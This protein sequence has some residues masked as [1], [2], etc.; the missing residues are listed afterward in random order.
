M[1]RN[2]RNRLLDDRFFD[3]NSEERSVIEA[4]EI[5]SSK[6]MFNMVLHTQPDK[7]MGLVRHELEKIRSLTRTAKSELALWLRASFEESVKMEQYVLSLM[8]YDSSSVNAL[9][10]PGQNGWRDP[11]NNPLNNLPVTQVILIRQALE[12]MG[13]MAVLVEVIKIVL[14]SENWDILTLAA[15]TIT[16]N[17]ESFCVLHPLDEFIRRLYTQVTSPSQSEPAI[18]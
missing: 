8:E 6:G 13:D 10:R 14:A 4:R 12:E 3:C 18:G 2:L 11:L 16:F 7:Y 9:Y 5:L 15:D 1:H 17:L